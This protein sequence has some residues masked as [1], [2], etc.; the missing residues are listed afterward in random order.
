VIKL[1]LFLWFIA[2]LLSLLAGAK[3]RTWMAR[4]FFGGFCLLLLGVFLRIVSRMF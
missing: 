3:A 4:L 1:A 2:F